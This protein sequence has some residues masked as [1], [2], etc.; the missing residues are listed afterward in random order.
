MLAPYPLAGP[1]AACG[2]GGHRAAA[3]PSGKFS[4]CTGM[5]SQWGDEGVLG[6]YQGGAAQT[7]WAQ[8]P[9]HCARTGGSQGYAPLAAGGCATLGNWLRDRDVE[10]SVG[11]RNLS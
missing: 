1:V 2:C 4:C 7:L 10:L 8:A 3:C 5:L 11:R 6:V 9:G